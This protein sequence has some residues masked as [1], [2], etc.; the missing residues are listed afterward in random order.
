MRLAILTLV[1]VL[2]PFTVT[3]TA[4]H[5]RPH[6]HKETPAAKKNF[7]QTGVASWYGNEFRNH[8]T[9][10]GERYNPDGLTAAHRTL[11]MGTLVR[12]TNLGNN[13]SVVVRI[14]NRGPYVRHRI[15]DL[16]RGAARELSITHPGI[17]RVRVEALRPGDSGT[18]FG[19]RATATW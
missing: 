12:V 19:G 8:K 2:T 10:N 3:E 15:I 13:R 4:P 18:R 1:C 6:L 14:N 9:A 16:S 11:P 7:V 17:A 5:G